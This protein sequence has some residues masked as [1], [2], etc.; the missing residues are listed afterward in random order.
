MELRHF[1]INYGIGVLCFCVFLEKLESAGSVFLSTH[2]T[3]W[4]CDL[5]EI[6]VGFSASLLACAF[7]H[8]HSH[9][10]VF[11]DDGEDCSE[12]AEGFCVLVLF[13]CD[14]E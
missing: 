7:E 4:R 3:D 13:C 1:I 2:V 6:E 12:L 10:V 11:G 5:S 8:L 9:F 14:L